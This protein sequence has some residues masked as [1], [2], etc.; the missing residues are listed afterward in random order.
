MFINSYSIKYMYNHANICS[1]IMM[2]EKKWWNFMVAI[3]TV[4]YTDVVVVV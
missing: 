1:H 3:V 4:L 2:V